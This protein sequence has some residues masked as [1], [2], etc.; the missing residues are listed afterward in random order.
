[1]THVKLLLASIRGGILTI[2]RSAE[3]LVFG[4]SS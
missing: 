3:L 4:Y 1:M 2:K